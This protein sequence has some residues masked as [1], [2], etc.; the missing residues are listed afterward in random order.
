M[1]A[2]A[3]VIDILHMIVLNAPARFPVSLLMNDMSD[4]L[5][6]L[7][8]SATATHLQQQEDLPH[9]NTSF[10]SFIH[11]DVRYSHWAWESVCPFWWV[12]VCVAGSQLTLL[13][14]PTQYFSRRSRLRILPAPLFGRASE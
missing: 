2:L 1:G 4:L 8:Y 9:G 5:D 7:V 3:Q 11:Y 10:L 13:L 14:L 12:L 6:L